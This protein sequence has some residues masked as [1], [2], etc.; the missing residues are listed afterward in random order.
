MK[1][2][3]EQWSNTS[4][5]RPLATFF[6]LIVSAADINS[7]FFSKRV[8]VTNWRSSVIKGLLCETQRHLSC[9]HFSHDYQQ[10]VATGILTQLTT[11]GTMD[12]HPRTRLLLFTISVFQMYFALFFQGCLNTQDMVK[13]LTLIHNIQKSTQILPKIHLIWYYIMVGILT[14]L[15]WYN[16]V[17]SNSN[18]EPPQ[19]Y[20]DSAF[21]LGKTWL[22][23]CIMS[24]DHV[25]PKHQQ[26]RSKILLQH[27][28]PGNI[29]SRF[30]H[31]QNMDRPTHMF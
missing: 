2:V 20:S 6:R 27:S 15:T 21:S 16:L 17:R 31:Q 25:E 28:C 9:K 19:K 24:V 10:L 23:H 4:C 12:T 3:T 8:Y 26:R 11:S 30:Y 5:T 7:H 29:C 22:G 1:W 14:V 18:E 13:S